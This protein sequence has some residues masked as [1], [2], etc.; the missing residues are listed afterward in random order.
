MSENADGFFEFVFRAAKEFGLPVILL[1]VMIYLFREAASTVHKTLLVP[2][3]ES[4]AKFLDTT[5]HTLREISATQSR[6]A[7]TL[8]ELADVQREIRRQVAGGREPV[9]QP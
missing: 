9:P 7:D 8:E 5:Q 1:G 3:V 2:M 4:H 6:Q